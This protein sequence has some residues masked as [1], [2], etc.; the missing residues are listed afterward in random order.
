MQNMKLHDEAEDKYES[1]FNNIIKILN[2]ICSK[3]IM[4]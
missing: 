3:Q 4:I 2:E 1:I